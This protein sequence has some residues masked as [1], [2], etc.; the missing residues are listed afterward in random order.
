MLIVKRGT[1]LR[2]SGESLLLL[3]LHSKCYSLPPKFMV[4]ICRQ[5]L[6]KETELE[7][8]RRGCAHYITTAAELLDTFNIKQSFHVQDYYKGVNTSSHCLTMHAT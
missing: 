1:T 2:A 6:C 8:F 7:L 4:L 5:A 3:L